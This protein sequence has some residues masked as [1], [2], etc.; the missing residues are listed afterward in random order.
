MN[1]VIDKILSG[2]SDANIRFSDF[3]KLI[4]SLGFNER[5]KGDHYIYSKKGIFE[6]INIQPRKDGKAKPYQVKQVRNII[7]NYKLLK[8]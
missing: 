5:I 1:K 4:L 3:R 6:I 2:Y 7:T 8:E